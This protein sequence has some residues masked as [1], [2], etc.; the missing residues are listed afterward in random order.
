MYVESDLN[1]CTTYVYHCGLQGAGQLNAIK[2]SLMF[3]CQIVASARGAFLSMHTHHLSLLTG[4]SPANKGK[5]PGKELLPVALGDPE[6]LPD[7][8]PLVQ[9]IV[10]K[11][12]EFKDDVIKLL[13]DNVPFLLPPAHAV[14]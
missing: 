3:S 9:F 11:V 1:S 4:A 7:F 8:E 6:A 5:F 13:N 12:N 10:D 2:S 14:G